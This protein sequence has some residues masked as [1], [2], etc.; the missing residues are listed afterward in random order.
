MAIAATETHISGL[1]VYVRPELFAPVR[2]SIEAFTDCEIVTE[3][4]AGKLVLVMETAGTHRITTTMDRIQGLTGVINTVMVYHH[5]EDDVS[6]DEEIEN[7]AN[8]T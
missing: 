1:I 6:L 4:P 8:A 2:S 5:C 3:D 7:E